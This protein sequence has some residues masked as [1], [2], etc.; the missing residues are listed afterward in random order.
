MAVLDPR[1]LPLLGTLADT[2][3]DWLA[4][5][6]VEMVRRGREPLEA[7]DIL[8]EA[9][10]KVRSQVHSE[11]VT[12]DIPVVSEPILGDEQLTWAAN[13][14]AARLGGVLADLDAGYAMINAIAE[15]SGD[16]F[17]QDAS[18]LSEASSGA[19]LRIALIGQ[20]GDAIEHSSIESAKKQISSLRE[21][22]AQWALEAKGRT[23]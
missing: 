10:E 13:Y 12:L 22:L 20:E 18:E 2:G 7:E 15:D 19:P 4:F 21:A 9:R 11:H 8:K 14:V 6:I 3:V 1:L 17:W 16:T 5:E 23:D